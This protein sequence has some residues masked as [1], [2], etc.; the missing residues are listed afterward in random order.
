MKGAIGRGEEGLSES[1]RAYEARRAAKAGVSLEKW[2]EQKKQ[3]QREEQKIQD[4]YQNRL[5]QKNKKN[6]FLKRLIERLHKPF[7]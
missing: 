1:Q 2:M 3:R 5:E 6:G 4:N 7:S